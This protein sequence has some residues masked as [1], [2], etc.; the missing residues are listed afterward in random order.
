MKNG[1]ANH[2]LNFS[3]DDTEI[4]VYPEDKRTSKYVGVTYNK[5][6]LKWCVC[7]WSKNEYKTVYNGHYNIEKTAAHASDALGRILI[8]N[9][10]Q[11][12]KLNLPEQCPKTKRKRSNKLEY[13]QDK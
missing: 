11:R 13:P 9:G 6:L 2:K 5:R 1:E 4:P 10:E 7:R 12:H 8:E 3:D